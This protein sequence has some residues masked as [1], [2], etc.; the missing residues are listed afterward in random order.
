MLKLEYRFRSGLF[1]MDSSTSE[2][3]KPDQ[4]EKHLR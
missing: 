3:P 2:P 1:T 4:S